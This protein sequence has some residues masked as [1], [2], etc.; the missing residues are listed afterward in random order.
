MLKNLPP[1]QETQETQVQSLGWEDPLEQKIVTNYSILAW[2]FHGQRSLRGYSPWG[3]KESEM[4][5]YAHMH[6]Y[7]HT[8]IYT[9]AHI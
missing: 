9:H 6:T 5:E 7:T 2:K 3:R 8:H 1:N 4:T